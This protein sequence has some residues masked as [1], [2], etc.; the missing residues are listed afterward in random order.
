MN[1]PI[2]I[3]LSCVATPSNTQFGEFSYTFGGFFPLYLYLIIEDRSCYKLFC[4]LIRKARDGEGLNLTKMRTSIYT[5]LSRNDSVIDI[6][7]SIYVLTKYPSYLNGDYH[8]YCILFFLSVAMVVHKIVIV[9]AHDLFEKH[10]IVRLDEKDKI[11]RLGW[12]IGDV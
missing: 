2:T 4:N 8:R 9:M 12:M 10:R 1:H 7:V 6:L 5:V 3:R 11:A